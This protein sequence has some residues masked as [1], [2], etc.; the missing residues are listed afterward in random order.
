MPKLIWD[1][2]LIDIVR[3][4]AV[5]LAP[6]LEHFIYPMRNRH[7]VSI[8]GAEHGLCHLIDQLVDDAVEL[9][10]D[11]LALR[12][13]KQDEKEFEDSMIGDLD[14]AI[15]QLEVQIQ[16][17][18][19]FPWIVLGPMVLLAVAKLPMY[20]DSKPLWL[21]PMALLCLAVTIATLRHELKNKQEPRLRALKELRDKLT[22]P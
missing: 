15:F 10:L 6:V 12:R 1:F 22:K 3:H 9:A 20:Y 4:F 19:I 2:C 21:T 13:R 11:A 18:R 7:G 16:R 5:P 17:Y 8:S 14:R